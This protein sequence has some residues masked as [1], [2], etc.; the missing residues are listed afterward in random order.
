MNKFEKYLSSIHKKQKWMIYISIVCVI[1]LVIQNFS[2]PLLEK[3]EALLVEI[4]SLEK[5]VASNS[6]NTIKKEMAAKS[7]MLLQLNGEIETQKE[8]ITSLMSSLYAIKYAFF[9]EK[10]FANALDE[11]LK[12]SIKGGVDIEY[13]K[14][15]PLKESVDAHQILKHKKRIEIRG[16]GGYKEIVS[17][18]NHIENF[19]VLSK[20]SN[21]TMKSGNENVTFVLLWDVYGIGL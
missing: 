20:F 14:N 16:D 17:F 8:T 2:T 18:I 3:H 13:I 15:I 1:A 21:I 11:M 9:N 10:E 4:E 6:A 5:S 12:Q 7:K 19:N